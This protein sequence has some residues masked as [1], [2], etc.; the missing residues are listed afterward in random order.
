MSMIPDGASLGQFTAYTATTEGS[1]FLV[2]NSRDA[3]NRILGAVNLSLIRSQA[4]KRWDLQSDSGVRRLASKLVTTVRVIQS[5]NLYRT[6][7]T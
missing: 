5:T 2:D 1:E 3:M 6:N 7:I 4:R